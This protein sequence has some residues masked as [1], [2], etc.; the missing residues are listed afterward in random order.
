MNVYIKQKCPDAGVAPDALRVRQA[1]AFVTRILSVFGL[2]D[3]TTDRLGFSAAASTAVGDGAPAAPAP[4]NSTTDIADTFAE[5]RADLA[6]LPSVA[7]APPESGAALAALAAVPSDAE[8]RKMSPDAA[9]DALATVRDTARSVAR[10]AGEARDAV[11]Q[12][13]DDLRDTKLVTMGIKLEDKPEGSVWMRVD[14]EE[15][16]SEVRRLHAHA[17]C[18][19]CALERP[20]FR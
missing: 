19:S 16:R 20:C 1:A 12:L 7:L 5:F 13:C 4:G 2:T 14:P 10:D 3:G 11:M 17:C 8:I 15:L 6:A 9:M 18:C